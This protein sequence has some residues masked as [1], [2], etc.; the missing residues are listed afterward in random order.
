MIMRALINLLYFL[1]QRNLY[2][3]LI[4]QIINIVIIPIENPKSQ[5]NREISKTRKISKFIMG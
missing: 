4:N 2:L 1:F 3:N 5:V